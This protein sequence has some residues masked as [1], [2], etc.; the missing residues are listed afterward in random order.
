MKRVTPDYAAEHLSELLLEVQAGEEIEITDEGRVL[1]RLVAPRTL[2]R[3][4]SDDADAPSDE[5]EQAF[6]GD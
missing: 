5:V 4:S 6:H 3:G 2:V 1:A